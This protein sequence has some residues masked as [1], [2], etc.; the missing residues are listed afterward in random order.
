[1][2]TGPRASVTEKVTEYQSA[3]V[4]LLLVVLTWAFIDFQ[5][6]LLNVRPEIVPIAVTMHIKY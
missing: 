5:G 6:A 1:M 4:T 2:Q 3:Y